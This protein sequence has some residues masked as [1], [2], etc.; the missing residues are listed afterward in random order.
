MEYLQ[1]YQ[2]PFGLSKVRLGNKN[3]G[4]YVIVN[5]LDY[6][7]YVSCGIGGDATFDI[8]FVQKHPS[9]FMLGGHG[10]QRGGVGVDGTVCRPSSFPIGLDFIQKNVGPL[11]NDSYTNLEDVFERYNDVFLK[12]DIEG[13]EWGWLCEKGEFIVPK[14]K[15]IVIEMHGMIDNS[16]SGSEDEKRKALKL[17]ASTHYLVHAHGN[18]NGPMSSYEGYSVPHVI[19]LTYLRKDVYHNKNE[20]ETENQIPPLN[21]VAFPIAGLDT[22]N[23]VSTTDLCLD[24]WPFVFVDRS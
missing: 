6:D 19:E 1:T 8:D 15:Q 13:G 12:M 24:Q 2:L 17:L 3:D 20:N 21:T 22:P 18:N 9:L 11:N 16:W 4:G 10:G 7:Y 14:C 23:N 5:G